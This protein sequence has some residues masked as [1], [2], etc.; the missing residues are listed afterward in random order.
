MKLSFLI[1]GESGGGEAGERIFDWAVAEGLKI[2]GMTRKKLSLEDIFVELTA[3]E[4]GGR[5]LTGAR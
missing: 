1:P 5:P 4:R 2:L 3:E